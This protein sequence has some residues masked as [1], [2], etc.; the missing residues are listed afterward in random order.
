MTEH[1]SA[2]QYR[3]GCRC[4]LCREANRVYYRDYHARRRSCSPAEYRADLHLRSLAR[5]H[6]DG[7]TQAVLADMLARAVA[8]DGCLVWGGRLSGNGYPLVTIGKKRLRAHRLVAEAVHG[9]LQGQTVHHKCANR[10]CIEPTHLQPVSLRDNLAEMHQRRWFEKRI[11]ELEAA[12]AAESP[13][14]PLLR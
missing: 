6:R 12:L 2:S 3:Q 5:A 13:G 10:A 8:V 1:G 11:A 7:D 4:S 14:H 9:P